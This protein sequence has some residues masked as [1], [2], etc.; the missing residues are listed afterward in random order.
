MEAVC[1]G[2]LEGGSSVFQAEGH[3]L[4]CEGAPWGYE[5]HLIMVFFLDLDLVTP[6]K[7]I[8]EGK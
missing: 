2:A 5:C 3:D 1:H 7:S 4:V 6:K 8:H